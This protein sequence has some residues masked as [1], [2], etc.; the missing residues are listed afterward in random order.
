[1]NEVRTSRASDGSRL[2]WHVFCP[3]QSV[4]LGRVVLIPG[5]T[6]PCHEEYTPV[7]EALAG[8]LVDAGYE[9]ATIAVRGHQGAEGRYSF[10]NAVDDI[11]V[12]LSE[13][14]SAEPRRVA[15]FARSS[16]GP[17]ALRLA[18]CLPQSVDRILLWGCSPKVVYDQLFGE[19]SDGSYMRACVDYGTCFTVD[20]AQTLF[21]PEDELQHVQVPVWLG[22]GSEDEYTD[23][24]IQTQILGNAQ[25][26]ESLLY[27][28]PKCPHAVKSSMRAWPAYKSMILTWLSWNFSDE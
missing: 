24:A 10:P 9:C 7:Y 19:Q 8:V 5:L 1:M 25:H 17:L 15:L 20:F 11:Q 21:F 3:E 14:K 2:Q 22:L 4:P 6:S 27:F 26:P 23:C 16:G 12:V 13:W 18:R 28:L